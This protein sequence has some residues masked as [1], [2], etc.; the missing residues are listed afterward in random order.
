MKMKRHRKNF[1]SELPISEI[2]FTPFVDI[3]LVL[4]IIFIVTTPFLSPYGYKIDVPYSKYSEEIQTDSHENIFIS[5]D[6]NANLF[7]NDEATD[8][9]R[10]SIIFKNLLTKSSTPP[11][12]IIIGDKEVYYDNI[13][14]LMDTLRNFGIVDFTLQLDRN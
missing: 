4:L 1:D 12:V 10:L 9:E 13:I 5:I 2:N 3:V 7:Y 14:K 11:P 8:L 6:K